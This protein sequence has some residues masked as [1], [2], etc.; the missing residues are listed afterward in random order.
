MM[1]SLRSHF[2]DARSLLHLRNRI[3]L[4][5]YGFLLFGNLIHAGLDITQGINFLLYR[6]D[7]GR[8]LFGSAD[9]LL[10]RGKLTLN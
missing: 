6:R 8:R 2:R 10:H 1:H 3:D 5:L 7:C 4:R 9:S